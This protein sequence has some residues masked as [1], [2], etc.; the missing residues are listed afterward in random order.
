MRQGV[1]HV[2]D[3][4]SG[5]APANRNDRTI[6]YVFLTYRIGFSRADRFMRSKVKRVAGMV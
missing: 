4:A 3:G 2:G 1:A 6:Q 5:S